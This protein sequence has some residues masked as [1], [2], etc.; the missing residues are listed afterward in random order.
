MTPE[1]ED[2]LRQLGEA[3]Q[4]VTRWETHVVGI[5]DGGWE[6][7]PGSELD[8]EDKLAHPFTV[9]SAAWSAILAS[10]SHL[11]TLRDSL[12]QFTGP[13][14]VQAKIHTHGQLSLVRGALENASL[15]YWLL[16][17]DQ[18]IARIARRVQE[19][20]DEVKQLESVRTLVSTPTL[21]TMPQREQGSVTC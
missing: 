12:F 18:S 20:W 3:L 17:P 5:R 14:N 11:G 9:S 6:A 1:E 21:K 8:A 15:G 19:D 13:T 10:I 7:A 16:Q 4:A 2:H